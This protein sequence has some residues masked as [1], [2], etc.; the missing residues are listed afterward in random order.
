MNK[1]EKL[2]KRDIEDRV[3]M[4]LTPP[5]DFIEE[6]FTAFRMKY[7]GVEIEY[8][9]EPP[10]R[11]IDRVIIEMETGENNAD[12]MLLAR[13]QMELLKLRGFIDRYD[14]PENA[15]F[16]ERARDPDG[17]ATQIDMVPFSIAYNT[18]KVAPHELPTQYED[19]LAPK[20]KGRLIY[21][22]PRTRGSGWYADMKEYL[23]E[24]FFRQLVK[25]NLCYERHCEERLC[26]GNYSILVA[27][28]VHDI[29]R[30]KDKGA[31]VDWIPM[32]IVHFGGPFAVLF[33]KAKHPNLGK[34]LI[35]F[36]L[37]VEGQQIISRY[38]IPNRPGVPIREKTI[39]RVMEKL[40]GA[41]L[42]SFKANHGQIYHKYH[43]EALRLF[44]GNVPDIIAG[45]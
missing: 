33:H 9:H 15:T 2:D 10:G 18:Q 38:R 40:K 12:I 26:E 4:Y 7:P 30:M 41:K 31:P 14:S 22:D 39:G 6:L 11:F 37:S 17:Y 24:D 34:R 27:G 44:S 45:Q 29:E 5:P 32:P 21:P 3:V 23:G 13:Q 1:I 20:W 19:L 25:Q 8:I 36:L 16:P 42:V 28:I 35:D 43:A